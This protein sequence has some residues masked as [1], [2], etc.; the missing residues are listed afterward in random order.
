MNED[1]TYERR[2]ISA[3]SSRGPRTRREEFVIVWI[4]SKRAW[5]T[6]APSPC[7][8]E[9]TTSE[10]TDWVKTSAMRGTKR[11]QV[12][13]TAPRPRSTGPTTTTTSCKHWMIGADVHPSTWLNATEERR[14]RE[15]VEVWNWVKVLTPDLVWVNYLERSCWFTKTSAWRR[16][17]NRVRRVG[18][19]S[20][21]TVIVVTSFRPRGNSKERVRW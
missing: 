16:W 17:E 18:R 20:F 4:T 15:R 10:R 7:A 14:R 9:A 2:V 13:V 1:A 12:P 11:G 3:K 19:R 5:W 21:L 6:T 8:R